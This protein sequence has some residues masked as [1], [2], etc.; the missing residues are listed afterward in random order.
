MIECSESPALICMSCLKTSQ[1]AFSFRQSCI[2][3]DL[4]FKSSITKEFLE[5]FN[6][7]ETKPFELKSEFESFAVDEDADDFV[8]NSFHCDDSDDSMPL[9]NLIP[10]KVQ[11]QIKPPEKKVEVQQVKNIPITKIPQTHRCSFFHEIF[12]TEID[13]FSHKIQ[14]HDNK[15]SLECVICGSNFGTKQLLRSHA[16]TH[17]RR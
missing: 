13:L 3:G 8:D 4:H 14:V 2:Q 10:A 9:Q 1:N 7:R 15:N 16:K 11:S 5:K 6:L 17:M 12:P